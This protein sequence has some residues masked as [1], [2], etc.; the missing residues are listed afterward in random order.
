MFLGCSL[1]LSVGF[2]LNHISPA[3]QEAVVRWQIDKVLHFFAGYL[4]VA[5]AIS[6]LGINDRFGL[7]LFAFAIGVGWEVIQLF[8]DVWNFRAYT[9]DFTPDLYDSLGDLAAD[10]LGALGYWLLHLYGR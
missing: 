6:F 10:M 1:I 7:F 5:A 9:S 3:V 8:A 4:C 2:A